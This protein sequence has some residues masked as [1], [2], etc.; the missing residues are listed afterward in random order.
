MPRM[1]RRRLR[2]VRLLW[3]INTTST[4]RGF[5]NNSRS[6]SSNIKDI[7]LVCCH[8]TGTNLPVVLIRVVLHRLP[9]RRHVV[10]RR[11]TCPWNTSWKSR[12]ILVLQ[13]VPITTICIVPVQFPIGSWSGRLRS[14]YRGKYYPDTHDPSY[15]PTSSPVGQP[16]SV[17]MVHLCS[18]PRF[19]ILRSY[20]SLWMCTSF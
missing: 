4:V 2:P 13:C 12:K 9:R 15:Y 16:R 17:R 6:S 5:F 18:C 14:I 1:R 20:M 7:T 19:P 3:T 10:S 8:P 11:H